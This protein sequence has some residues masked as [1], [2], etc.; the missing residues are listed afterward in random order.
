MINKTQAKMGCIKHWYGGKKGYGFIWPEDG[1]EAV[2]MHHT[3]MATRARL[4]PLKEGVRVSY[5]VAS[6]K[7][8]GLWAKNVRIID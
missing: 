6:K 8:C 1:G 2:F 5:Q 4:R 3:G 7:M